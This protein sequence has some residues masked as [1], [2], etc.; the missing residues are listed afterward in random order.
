M[1]KYLE[2]RLEAHEEVSEL[3]SLRDLLVVAGLGEEVDDAGE[4]VRLGQV[5]ERVE[6]VDALL[7]QLD[8]L[9]RVVLVDLA[10]KKKNVSK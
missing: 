10:P 1:L 7:V 4:H 5:E 2:D 8:E 3:E 9:V 6:H